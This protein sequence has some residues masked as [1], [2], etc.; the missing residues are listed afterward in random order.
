MRTP[1]RCPDCGQ[2][3]TGAGRRCAGCERAYQY[4]RNR[5]SRRAA[6]RDPAFRSL[7]PTGLC[8]WGCGR[9][10]TERDHLEGLGSDLI[11]F[12]CKPCNS[13]RHGRTHGEW[14]A[15]ESA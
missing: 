10:A 1:R 2:S 15:K 12:A 8:Y 5:D 6:Y 3:F 7:V 11:V 4:V 13:A 14:L 9:P